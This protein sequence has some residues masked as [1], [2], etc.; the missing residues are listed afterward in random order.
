MGWRPL[1]RA[2]RRRLARIEH[3]AVQQAG[4][5]PCGAS[6]GPGAV[7]E[8]RRRHHSHRGRRNREAAS[9]SL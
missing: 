7:R 5:A 4:Q 2:T 1:L 6:A 8:H 3:A 9:P